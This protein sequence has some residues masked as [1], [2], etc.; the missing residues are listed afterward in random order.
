MLLRTDFDLWKMNRR[1]SAKDGIQAQP[2]QYQQPIQLPP[3]ISHNPS[4][5]ASNLIGQPNISM[6]YF[7][8][9]CRI[10]LNK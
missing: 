8:K 3:P 4:K 9:M 6:K 1:L 2:I 5:S 10:E 7:S